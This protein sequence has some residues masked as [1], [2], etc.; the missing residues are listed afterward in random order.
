M[1]H[2]FRWDKKYLHWGVTAFCVIVCCVVVA[3][4]LKWL[5]I[6]WQMFK[7]LVTQLSPPSAAR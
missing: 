2:G 4:L 1:K 7:K 5:P 3:Y 6:L